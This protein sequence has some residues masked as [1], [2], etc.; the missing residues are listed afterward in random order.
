MPRP[1]MPRPRTPRPRRPR[2]PLRFLRGREGTAAVEFGL[3]AF[4]LLAVLVAIFE[5]GL[6][7]LA[8]QNLETALGDAS[9]Q[10]YTGAF[11]TAPANK[12]VSD[13][14]VMLA[15]L[16][17]LLCQHNGGP[18]ATVFDCA[19]VRLNV[20]QPTSFAARGASATI[21]DAASGRQAWNADFG[22]QYACGRANEIVVIQ[23]AVEFPVLLSQLY[24]ASSLLANGR[25]V[26]Q[27][28]VAFRVEPFPD[29]ACT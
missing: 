5:I 13:P 23:A 29:G 18:R 20:I 2:I 12:G 10:I 8:G 26:L 11:Q 17:S 7:F 3:I 6:T 28:A 9:R 25:R 14:K 4:P 21:T 15:R 22:S 24:A 1:R 27:A 16:G 19:R